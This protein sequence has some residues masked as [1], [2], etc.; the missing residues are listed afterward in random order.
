MCVCA[1]QLPLQELSLEAVFYQLYLKS[2]EAVILE[3]V[4][5]GCV[6][7]R[8]SSEAV[9]NGRL[10]RLPLGAAVC[11]EAARAAFHLFSSV[12]RHFHFLV[13]TR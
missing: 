13:W 5:R 10:Q 9:S 1:Y 2:L 11:I 7:T 4:S 6:H 8:L 12:A 3:A